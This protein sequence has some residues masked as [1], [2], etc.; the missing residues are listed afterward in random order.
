MVQASV[1][2]LRANTEGAGRHSLTEGVRIVLHV[3]K[4]RLKR[5]ALDLAVDS[6]T[7]PTDLSSD[8]APRAR[9]S[10]YCA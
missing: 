3:T 5:I 10:Y 6:R 7:M 1:R 4:E 9:H 8:P 2:P